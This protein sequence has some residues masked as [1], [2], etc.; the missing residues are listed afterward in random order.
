MSWSLVGALLASIAVTA[1]LAPMPSQ[2]LAQ[3]TC[4][5]GYPS[6]NIQIMAPAAPGGAAP[7]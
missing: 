6:D 2:V 1:G 4:P 5:G 7:G 3:A